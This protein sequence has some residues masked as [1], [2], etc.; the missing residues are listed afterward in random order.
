M[1]KHIRQHIE[2]YI[3]HFVIDLVIYLKQI[4]KLKLQHL[5][6]QVFEI[7]SHPYAACYGWENFINK[8]QKTFNNIHLI[9]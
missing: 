8:Y 3:I 5:K 1:K 9:L 6:Y 7:V 2:N 4:S